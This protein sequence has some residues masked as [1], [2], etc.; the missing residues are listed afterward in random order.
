MMFKL[1]AVFQSIFE[2][3]LVDNVVQ[4]YTLFQPNLILNEKF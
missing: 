4:W 1:L 2:K 3:T